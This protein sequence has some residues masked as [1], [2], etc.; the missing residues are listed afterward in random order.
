MTVYSGA[1]IN[2]ISIVFTADVPSAINSTLK[3]DG[4]NVDC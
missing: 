3:F 2:L 1:P 4:E